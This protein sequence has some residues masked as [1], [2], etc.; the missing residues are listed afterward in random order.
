[1]DRRTLSRHCNIGLAGGSTQQIGGE[2]FQ[3]AKQLVPGTSSGSVW[4]GEAADEPAH[5]Y[6]RPHRKSENT[7][8]PGANFTGAH[9]LIPDW[10]Y[11]NRVARVAL[12]RDSASQRKALHLQI[13][14]PP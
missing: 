12:R 11:L 4:W 13:Q 10:Q 1:L 5:E 14:A 2:E 3:Q 9:G 6:A 8:C 7:C